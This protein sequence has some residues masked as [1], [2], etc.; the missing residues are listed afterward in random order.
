[1]GHAGLPGCDGGVDY[2]LA[3]YSLDPK[4]LGVT[5]YSYGGFLTD[6]IITQTWDQA[7]VNECAVT[8]YASRESK[9]THAIVHGE[10]DRRVPIEEAE[11]M[12]T[13]L[14]KLHVP[15][16]FI[17]IPE[18]SRL[19]SRAAMVAPISVRYPASYEASTLGRYFA[20]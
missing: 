7:R 20:S 16:K 12:Y 4:R 6:W 19:L 17:A 13:A 2:A 18:T 15:A 9:N 10:A 8:D 5:G 1:M 3:H 14:K 11:R